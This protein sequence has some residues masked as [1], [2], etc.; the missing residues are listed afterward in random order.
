MIS[1]AADMRYVGQEHPV[2]VP[3]ADGLFG[4][5]DRDGI[6]REFDKVH[7][8]RY[9][10][11]APAEPGEIVSLRSSIVGKMP[12]P[13]LRAY[14]NEGAGGVSG[15]AT[16]SRQ[17]YFDRNAG[18]R[19]TPSFDRT[20]LKPGHRIEGPAVVEEHASTTVLFPGDTLEVDDYLNL[21]IT[22]AG[23]SS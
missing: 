22:V 9:G 15:A 7:L 16:G 14:P 5:E 11:N 2:T 19:E 10:T 13:E 23:Y 12:V 20:R 8:E 4:D 18:Y 6:K 1:R 17:I 3:L 21:I